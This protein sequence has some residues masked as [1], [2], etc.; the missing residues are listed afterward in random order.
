MATPRS[1][2]E[3][4]GGTIP[5]MAKLPLSNIA[6]TKAWCR[7]TVS[8]NAGE[9]SIPLLTFFE[10][11]QRELLEVLSFFRMVNQPRI[12]LPRAKDFRCETA[13]SNGGIAVGPFLRLGQ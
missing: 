13:S 12:N 4:S 7:F 2:P 10:A 6:F 3:E 5:A 9:A 8:E 11:D 1:S